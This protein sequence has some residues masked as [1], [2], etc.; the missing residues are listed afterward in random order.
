ML[1]VQQALRVFRSGAATVALA[2]GRPWVS[3]RADGVRALGLLPAAVVLWR[4]GGLADIVLVGTIFEL[5]AGCVAFA[6]IR[7]R[8]SLAAC[9]PV[10]A[11]GMATCLA[12]WIGAG[13]V[14]AALCLV[15]TV[16]LARNLHRAVGAPRFGRVLPG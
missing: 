6:G 9:G 13:T 10:A 8:V 15:A 11:A 2:S 4:G 5:L 7:D 3:F 1:G 14:T 16:C 12:V